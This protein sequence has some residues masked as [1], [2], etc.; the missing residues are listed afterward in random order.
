[1]KLLLENIQYFENKEWVKAVNLCHQEVLQNLAENFENYPTCDEIT[2]I[3][4]RNHQKCLLTPNINIPELN[5]EG[6]S[7][8]DLTLVQKMYEE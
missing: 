2:Q 6:L 5:L 1:M 8:Q 3:L 7:D 4:E